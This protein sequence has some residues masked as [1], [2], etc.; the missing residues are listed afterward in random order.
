M[1]LV[2]ESK[3]FCGQ[4]QPARPIAR[5][6]STEPSHRS[7]EGLGL[8]P[9]KSTDDQDFY[10][11]NPALSFQRC[12]D[13]QAIMFWQIQVQ[14]DN[15]WSWWPESRPVISNKM[16]GRLSIPQYGELAWFFKLVQSPA[17]DFDISMVVVNDYNLSW[18][19]GSVQHKPLS[20]Q[21]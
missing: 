19:F 14:G 13:G 3:K 11:G 10:M 7:K 12:Q 15:A 2:A 8:G 9:C 4:G 16:K 20:L 21:K 17:Q 6:L 18:S 5:F 1:S